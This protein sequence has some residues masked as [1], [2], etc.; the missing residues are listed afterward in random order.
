MNISKI[1]DEYDQQLNTFSGVGT[2]T[3]FDQVSAAG[4]PL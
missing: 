2:L 4:S 1:N 3:P